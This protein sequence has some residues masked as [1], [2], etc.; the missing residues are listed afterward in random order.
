[1]VICRYLARG[2]RE[3]ERG[4]YD[5]QEQLGDAGFKE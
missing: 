3:T 1:M 4:S 2:V 5:Q